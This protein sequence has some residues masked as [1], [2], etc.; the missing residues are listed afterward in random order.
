MPLFCRHPFY[1]SQYYENWR[2][3]VSY[4]YLVYLF[5]GLPYSV[6]TNLLRPRRVEDRQDPCFTLMLIFRAVFRLMACRRAARARLQAALKNGQTRTALLDLVVK[7]F[8]LPIMTTFLFI[9]CGGFFSS[10]PALLKTAGDFYLKSGQPGGVPF[11]QP[12]NLFY[13]SAYHAIF[14]IDVGLSIIG[15]ACSSR[16]LGN[17]SRSVDPYFTG[18]LAAL[19]CYPPFNGITSNYLPY[20]QAFGGEPYTVLLAGLI[21]GAAGTEAALSAI[22]TALK[23]MTLFAFSIYVWATMAF[24]LRFS[25]LTHR[26]IISR[27]PYAYIRHPAFV[28]KNIAW[29]TENL[30]NFSSPWQF[31]FLAVWNY[32]YYLRAVTEERH[33]GM[34]PRYIE[35]MNRVKS[36]FIPGVFSD[37]P[38]LIEH[39][40]HTP[41][42]KKSKERNSRFQINSKFQ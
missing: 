23:I 16:W 2:I 18:W 28:A 7:I 6:L 42:P 15:Y 20:N 14:I 39:S 5:L 33:L 26:G 4:L 13:S 8:F 36:R 41:E 3:T 19:I 38:S 12:F 37:I 22:D 31:V 27:G 35:Y 9:E 30:R 11:A 24:G 17:K 32:I 25:N 1:T 29:W 21:G 10:F 34:D 40:R